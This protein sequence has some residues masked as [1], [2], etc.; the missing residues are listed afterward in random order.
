MY[1]ILSLFGVLSILAGFF[2]LP[3][4]L[5]AGVGAIVGGLVLMTL[6]QMARDIEKTAD[7]T[8]KVA[9]LLSRPLTTRPAPE[10]SPKRNEPAKEFLSSP[11]TAREALIE[12]AV[13]D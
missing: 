3:F 5:G 8:A 6:S 4:D 7:S 12:K 11:L 2:A 13:G 9:D 10:P 1:V